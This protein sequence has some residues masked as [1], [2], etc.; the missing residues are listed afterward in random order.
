MNL[1]LAQQ[2][3]TGYSLLIGIFFADS[4]GV[5]LTLLQGIGLERLV[6]GFF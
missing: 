1:P 2:I 5:Y 3:C 4:E 6:I